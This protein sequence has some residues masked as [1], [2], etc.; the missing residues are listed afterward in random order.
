MKSGKAE[1]DVALERF[2]A[3][4]G[5]PED[6]DFAFLEDVPRPKNLILFIGDGLGIATITA[7][8]IY[9]GQVRL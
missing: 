3:L 6:P 9:K 8:R 2:R 4:L 1:V 5:R 7:A